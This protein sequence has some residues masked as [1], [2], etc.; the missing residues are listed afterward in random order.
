MGDIIY[1]MPTMRLVAL[2]SGPVTLYAKDGLRSHDPLTT[3]IPLFKGLLEAQ[4]Y[5]EAVLPWN[6]EAT[7]D[8]DTCLW[9]EIGYPYGVTLATL[10]A[11]WLRL[12]PDLHTPWLD[13]STASNYAGKIIINR[14]PRYHND[15]FPWAKLVE[16]F[17]SRM[18]FI[19][20][21]SEHEAFCRECGR[22]AY[23]P[24]RNL[25]EAARAIAG[26]EL[27]IG[28]QSSCYAIAEGLKHDSIQETSLSTP[29]CIYRRPNATF[30]HDGALDFSFG[31]QRFQSKSRFLLRAHPNETPPTGWK[32][33]IGEHSANSYAF[34]L[35]VQEITA[36][37][38][39]HGARVP[40]NLHDLIIEQSS[41]GVQDHP[42][43]HLLQPNAEE[44]ARQ[45][46]VLETFHDAIL[47]RSAIS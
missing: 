42:V 4:D 1:L 10:Q 34:A 44:V 12:N 47:L 14:S 13:V 37:L 28:N 38:K 39:K 26:S 32:V 2:E 30:C 45:G 8:Y 29:D 18:L 23:Q 31:G 24:T 35:V 5:I 20:L 40:K 17:G 15:F 46:R 19:G 6:E 43:T 41:T 25:L 27:F 3:R 21:E 7:I 9:R 16:A 22:I 11:A 33:T 36:K